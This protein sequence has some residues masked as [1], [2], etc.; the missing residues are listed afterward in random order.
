MK[1]WSEPTI[2]EKPGSIGPEIQPAEDVTSHLSGSQNQARDS[3]VS[4]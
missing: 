1:K 4:L 2:Q 3:A